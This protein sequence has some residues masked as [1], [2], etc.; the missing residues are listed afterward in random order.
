MKSNPNEAQRSSRTQARSRTTGQTVI[1][2]AAGGPKLPIKPLQLMNALLAVDGLSPR[3]RYVGLV[4]VLRT[5]NDTGIAEIGQ[6]EL[7]A[8]AH[9]NVKPVIRGLRNL[10]ECG[11]LEVKQTL[12]TNRYRWTSV[13]TEYAAPKPR[14]LTPEELW[15]RSGKHAICDA[16]FEEG[17]IAPQPPEAADPGKGFPSRELVPI[18][19]PSAARLVAAAMD[20]VDL[21]EELL[22]AHG[23]ARI[24]LRGI[25]TP[26]SLPSGDNLGKLLATAR[27]LC[28]EGAP[29]TDVARAMMMAYVAIN[30]RPYLQVEKWP[31]GAIAKDLAYV[32]TEARGML[33]RW[34]KKAERAEL[35]L[36]QREDLA[37]VVV[38]P[39]SVSQHASAIAQALA[40]RTVAA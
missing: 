27:Q 29:Q 19:D 38:D 9:C 3:E 24:E 22:A 40:A 28:S 7:A 17:E 20:G 14:K 34:K 33:R 4:L 8:L 21:A 13:L 32:E 6:R 10:I 30:F 16:P 5:D 15:A 37:V 36:E 23:L 35:E 12:G 31:L 1:H 2:P 18:A 26:S 25:H 11:A 39:I